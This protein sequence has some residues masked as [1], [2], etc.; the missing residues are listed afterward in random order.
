MIAAQE[1]RWFSVRLQ[2]DTPIEKLRDLAELRAAPLLSGSAAFT[3]LTSQSNE[4][5]DPKQ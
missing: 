4:R 3:D 5:M 2:A 1:C